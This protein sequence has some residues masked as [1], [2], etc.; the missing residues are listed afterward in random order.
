MAYSVLFADGGLRAGELYGATDK[1]AGDVTDKPVDIA[2]TLFE[3][4]GIP[5]RLFSKTL[6]AG[7]DISRTDLQI[8]ALLG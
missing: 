5:I 3:A 8:T 4:L 6:W 1:H 2:A 7:L